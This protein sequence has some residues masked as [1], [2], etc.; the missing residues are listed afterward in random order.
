MYFNY[1]EYENKFSFHE[2][3]QNSPLSFM[4]DFYKTEKIAKSLNNRTMQI[5][6]PRKLSILFVIRLQV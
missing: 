2:P 4:F 1:I 5:K 3:K 6:I